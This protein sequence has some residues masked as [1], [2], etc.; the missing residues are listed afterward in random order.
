MNFG[1]TEISGFWGFASDEKIDIFKM[2][3]FTQ[4]GKQQP[5]TQTI[6]ENSGLKG[7]VVTKTKSQILRPETPS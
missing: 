1:K 5:K 6:A 3:V 2:T 7:T 4:Q